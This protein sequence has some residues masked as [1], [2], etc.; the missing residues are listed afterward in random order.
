MPEFGSVT[1][2]IDATGAMY[3][4]DALLPKLFDAVLAEP[5]RPAIAASVNARPPGNKHMRRFAE[6][7]AGVARASGRTLVAYQYSPLGGPLDTD[8]IR[9]LHAAHVP[10]LLGTSNAMRALRFLAQRSAYW[11]RAGKDDAAGVRTAQ[12]A[13]EHGPWDF[14]SARSLL[15]A[16]GIPVVAAELARSEDEAVAIAR[17]MA[18]PVAVKAEAPDLVH[19]SDVGCV[20]LGLAGDDAVIQAFRDVMANCA[21]A[22]FKNAAGALIQPMV[23]GVAEAFAGIID[24]PLFGPAVCFGMG[25]IFVEI[26]HDA[27]IEMAPLTRDVAH[28]MIRRTRAARL[29]D[30]ARG[31]QPGDVAALVHLLVRL[32]DFAAAHAGAF[33]ALDLN[34]I[35]VGRAGAG[36]VAVDIAIEE[37]TGAK[38]TP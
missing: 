10:F 1:N 21:K 31:R 4:D 19:K 27:T 22:G 13:V 3:D 33:R 36:A 14:L 5:G 9:T 23:S 32:G 34:P 7:M 35:I 18:T 30:G 16:S 38:E 11:A 8:V 20:R 6:T 17:R 37:R 24:D 15:V 26:L 29:L 2:P 25:G 12:A 28:D